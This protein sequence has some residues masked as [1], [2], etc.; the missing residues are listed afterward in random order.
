MK[1]AGPRLRDKVAGRP[2]LHVLELVVA[3]GL[4]S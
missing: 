4:P 1:A 2:E 3:K